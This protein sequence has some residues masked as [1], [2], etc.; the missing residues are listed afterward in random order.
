MTITKRWKDRSRHRHN[1][2]K[3]Y[4]VRLNK[5]INTQDI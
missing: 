5:E 4:H 2:V 1:L 3:R